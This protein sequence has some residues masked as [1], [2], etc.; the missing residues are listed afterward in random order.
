MSSHEQEIAGAVK[1]L[2]LSAAQFLRCDPAKSHAV[3][4]AAK[5]RFV[6]DEP[7]V[8]WLGFR[9]PHETHAYGDLQ[10]WERRLVAT[11]PPGTTR[12]WL[13]VE[14]DGDSY[15]VYDV[16]VDVVAGVIKEC[17]FL[18]YYLV[19]PEFNWIVSDTDHNQLI[20]VRLAS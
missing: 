18:E 5:G 9:R 16:E 10:D 2:A 6:V 20:F 13:I 8:W 14:S 3:A 17:S 15:P 12:C 1:V 4:I 11:I 19:D 7:R